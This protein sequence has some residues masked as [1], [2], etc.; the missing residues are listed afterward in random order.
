MGYTKRA[1]LRR[2]VLNR[3]FKPGERVLYLMAL[4]GII[5]LVIFCYFP[6]Y[7]LLMAF[8]QYNQVKGVFGS[9]FIGLKNFEFLF[10]TTDA[11]IITR[12][13]VLYNVVFI[14]T[15]MALSVIAALLLNALRTKGMAKVLQT[16][17]ML[18]YFLS[19][20]VISI[21]AYAFLYRNSGMVNMVL[22]S[23]GMEGTTNWYQVPRIWPWLLI[24]VNAW[25]N[26]GYSTVVYLAVISGISRDYY[27]AAMIDGASKFQQALHITLP[28]LRFIAGISL[29]M[30]MG[31]IFRGDFGLFYTVPMNTGTLFR[32]TDVLDTYIYRALTNLNNVGMSTAA[33]LYQ[34]VVGLVLILIVNQAVKKIDPDNGMF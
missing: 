31:S 21:I 16:V 3:Y 8:Q 13:T 11:F 32:V 12:N 20:A 5:F 29:I 14:I 1:G 23:L 27:E 4:P 26:V 10:T 2:G 28:H 30:S 34:S 18:P 24:L 25:K 6:M 19:Y 22:R 9:P 17:Y 15:N 33:G 7:G